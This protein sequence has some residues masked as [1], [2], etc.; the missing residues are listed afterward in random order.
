MS[1]WRSEHEWNWLSWWSYF[2]LQQISRH[3]G[4][5]IRHEFNKTVIHDTE[6]V[7]LKL[8]HVPPSLL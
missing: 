8:L 5:Q 3:N 1:L 6:N 2:G 4:L 7:K